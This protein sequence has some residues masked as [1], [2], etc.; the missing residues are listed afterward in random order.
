MAPAGLPGQCV[1][2]GA[3]AELARTDSPRLSVNDALKQPRSCLPG[4]PPLAGML[5]PLAQPCLAHP[6]GAYSGIFV[7]Q[8]L[9]SCY[10]KVRFPGGQC[11]CVVRSRFLSKR[12]FRSKRWFRSKRRCLYKRLCLYKRRCLSKRLSLQPN[13]FSVCLFYAGLKGESGLLRHARTGLPCDDVRFH[14][15]TGSSIPNGVGMCCPGR[16]MVKSALFS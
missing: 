4:Q 13:C 14:N 10:W 2:S 6:L 9:F 7:V 15:Y 12:R 3:N 5:K 8:R 1:P 16:S 11:L